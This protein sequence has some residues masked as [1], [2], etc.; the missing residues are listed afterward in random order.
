EAVVNQGLTVAIDRS[1]LPVERRG[2]GALVQLPRNA[3][4]AEQ[5]LLQALLG[6]LA[7]ELGAPNL[8]DDEAFDHVFATRL[9]Q[10]RLWLNMTDQPVERAGVRIEAFGIGLGGP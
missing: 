8:A 2:R 6:P 3:G 5:P 10:G 1:K 7:R 9:G 4:S